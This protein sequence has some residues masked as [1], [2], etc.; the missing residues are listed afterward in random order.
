VSLP[1][2]GGER[3]LADEPRAVLLPGQYRPR[4]HREVQVQEPFAQPVRLI[5]HL[6]RG[7]EA[8]IDLHARL[9]GRLACEVSC[10]TLVLFIRAAADCEKETSPVLGDDGWMATK[11]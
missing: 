2:A 10:S 8:L 11:S 5:P 7:Q 6:E 1:A 9:T 3:G 4:P